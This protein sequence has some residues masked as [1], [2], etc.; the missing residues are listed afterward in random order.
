LLS[1]H[2]MTALRRE[3]RQINGREG[4]NNQKKLGDVMMMVC[5][6]YIR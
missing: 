5:V 2:D 3:Y 1:K 4:R 6:L